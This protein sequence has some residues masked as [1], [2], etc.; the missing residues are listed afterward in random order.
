MYSRKPNTDGMYLICL[1]YVGLEV[2]QIS[3]FRF[4]RCSLCVD[5]YRF[6]IPN[7]KD[8]NMSKTFLTVMSVLR[9]FC[10]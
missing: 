7:L 9:K 4:L 6:S 3:D 5:L 1:G 2:V 8:P 10:I